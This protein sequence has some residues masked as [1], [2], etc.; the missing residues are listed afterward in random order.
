MTNAIYCLFYR[1]Q[2]RRVKDEQLATTR[3]QPTME[4]NNNNNNQ[5]LLHQ[6]LLLRMATLPIGN[7]DTLRI[8]GPHPLNRLSSMARKNG[9]LL[10]VTSSNRKPPTTLR[11]LTST[12]SS[13]EVSIRRRLSSTHSPTEATTRMDSDQ[14]PVLSRSRFKLAALVLT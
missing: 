13:K 12:R 7:E 8:A 4:H 6:L 5:Q 2:E 9:R 3:P 10:P 11:P 14:D 1:S